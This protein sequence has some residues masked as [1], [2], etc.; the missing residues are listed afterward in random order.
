MTSEAMTIA[1]WIDRIAVRLGAAGLYFGHGTDNARDE[2]AWLVL[3]VMGA[4]LDG[5]FTDW[6]RP[7]G[8]GAE[9]EILRLAESRCE[10]RQPLA[11]L[12]GKAIFAGLEFE[13]SP[14]VLI[15]RSP[16]AELIQDEF[17][18]WI[19]PEK[20]LRILDMCTGSAC[21]AIAAALQ[22]PGA[23]VDAVDIS[24]N[25]LKVAS[26]NVERHKVSGRVALIESN[27]F[28]SVPACQYD[29]IVANPP[30]VPAGAMGELPREY[31]EEP[32][33][34][35]ESGED[36]LDAVLSILVDAPGF[37]SEDGILLC[38]VGESEDRLAASLPRVPF[39]W[40][41]FEH[42]GSG[43][44]LLTKEQLE[45]AGAEIAAFIGERKNVV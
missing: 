8:P 4:R 15:P 23:Q 7:V 24:A 43:V 44:F 19:D 42:G 14:D 27:L 17:R 13:V 26:R 28:H 37:L 1:E 36:G 33:L 40:L 38:E 3:H 11:Y 29:L 6:G 5:G 45:E 22:Y 30:Y 35:L 9:A 20:A 31:R 16:I 21:I 10:T 2:A 12:T 34:G 39:L 41:E 25:A 32:P 18:P